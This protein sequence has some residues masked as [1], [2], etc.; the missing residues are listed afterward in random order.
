MN[1][2]FS[3]NRA[4]TGLPAADDFSCVVTPGTVVVPQGP[5]ESIRAPDVTITRCL[6][7]ISN[8]IGASITT[9]NNSG[10]QLVVSC[11]DPSVAI[12]EGIIRLAYDAAGGYDERVDV[13]ASNGKDRRSYRVRVS[14][15]GARGYHLVSTDYYT[16]GSLAHHVWTSILAMVEG[17]TAT[18]SARR[19][20]SAASYSTSSPSATRNSGLFCAELDLSAITFA[21]RMQYVPGTYS[22]G[23]TFP[24]YLVSPRHCIVANHVSA[25]S[26]ITDEK[27]T[28]MRQD[29]SFQTVAVTSK[30]R[31]GVKDLDVLYLAESV[32]GITPMATLPENWA[33]YLPCCNGDPLT[34]DWL[35]VVP[36]IFKGMHN[37]TGGTD[38]QMR[39]IGC[40]QI[41]GG[42][43][44]NFDW[45]LLGINAPLLSW[46]NQVAGGD[47]SGAT[48]LPINGEAVIIGTQF[49]VTNGPSIP[50][51]RTQ[52]NTAMNTL[53][54][55]PQGTYAMRTVDL[56]GFTKFG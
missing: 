45:M 3:S 2:L 50:A 43:M 48:L 41:G 7:Q 32:T 16:P 39:V 36:A 44:L 9:T 40:G 6:N 19:L 12:T 35:R 46:S 18:D 11:S 24:A 53:A 54:G 28:F 31:I 29:G 22:D 47:S 17:K 23:A 13:V 33:N 14:S 51:L 4:I 56:S 25:R 1:I 42:E 26:P 5:G 30:L 21:R 8:S 49:M 55:T 15:N 34:Y 52:I 20:Y 38:N 37:M 10:K 27:V